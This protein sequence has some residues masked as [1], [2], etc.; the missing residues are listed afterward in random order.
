MTANSWKTFSKRA[1]SGGKLLV[2]VADITQWY[3][4]QYYVDFTGIISS[5]R[6]HWYGNAERQVTICYASVG[7]SSSRNK[8]R[9]YTT[10]SIFRPVIVKYTNQ[11]N[12]TDIKYYLAL[13]RSTDIG[14]GQDIEMLYS[15]QVQGGT[16]NGL[17]TCI[18]FDNSLTLPDGYTMEKDD[19]VKFIEA[20]SSGSI[21]GTN[22]SYTYDSI[23]A[24][25]DRISVLESK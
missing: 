16:H 25:E 23:K 13:L 21:K 3:N 1:M 24:L 2:L 9:L 17:M 12:D 14:S 20:S 18:P 15:M 22:G 6:Q 8:H 5:N 11:D 4:S 19:N 7:Y 10:N